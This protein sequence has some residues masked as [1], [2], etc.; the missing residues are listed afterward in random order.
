MTKF[1]DFSP[2]LTDLKEYIFVQRKDNQLECYEVKIADYDISEA[3][4]INGLVL[5]ATE[6][7][8]KIFFTKK[9]PI[10]YVKLKKN[11]LESIVLKL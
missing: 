10:Q 7:K 2:T 3:Q 11:D 4:T 8:D 6:V 1:R 5:E 9:Q